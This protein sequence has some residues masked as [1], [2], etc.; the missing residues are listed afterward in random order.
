MTRLRA[1]APPLAV[2]AGLDPATHT[3]AA[4]LRRAVEAWV[5]AGHDE[6][7]GTDAPRNRRAAD[8]PG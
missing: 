6:I 4:A 1:G 8:R 5:K 3:V 7:E 2:V